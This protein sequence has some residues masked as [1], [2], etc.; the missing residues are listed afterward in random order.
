[1]VEGCYVFISYYGFRKVL[2]G[3]KFVFDASQLERLEFKD[4]HL[5][6]WSWEVLIGV[7]FVFDASQ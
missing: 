1:M 2:I 6:L 4:E 5:L 3:V 7:K